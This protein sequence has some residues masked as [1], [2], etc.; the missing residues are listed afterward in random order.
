MQWIVAKF[1]TTSIE[2]VQ[3]TDGAA[4]NGSNERKHSL[5]S[6]IYSA[7]KRQRYRMLQEPRALIPDSAARSTNGS[8]SSLSS[9][10]L[11]HSDSSSDTVWRAAY[12]TMK[13]AQRLEINTTLAES[14][15]LV[16]LCN[17]MDNSGTQSSSHCTNFSS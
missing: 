17:L 11:E 13:L 3:S 5:D 16:D 7:A 4:D 12:S 6:P 10:H 14:I 9:K 15:G 8:G 1:K 2:L